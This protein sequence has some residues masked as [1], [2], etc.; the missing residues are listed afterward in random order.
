MQQVFGGDEEVD[1]PIEVLDLNYNQG[2]V[3]FPIGIDETE[4]L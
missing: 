2:L 1:L 3:T 4:A